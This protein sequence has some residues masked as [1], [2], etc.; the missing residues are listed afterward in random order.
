M[1]TLAVLLLG[2]VSLCIAAC[3]A[4]D[5]PVPPVNTPTDAH[6]A[7]SPTLAATDTPQPTATPAPTSK[8]IP[9]ATPSPTPTRRR[10]PHRR[11]F[12]PRR[13][14]TRPL[15]PL[16]PRQ[17]PLRR[18]PP[19]HPPRRYLRPLDRPPRL[20]RL[21]PRQLP[22]RC[23]S[24]R[25]RR[26]QHPRRP[27]PSA[28]TLETWRRTSACLPQLGRPTRCYHTGKTGRWW[29]CSTEG[30]GDRSAELSSAS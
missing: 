28:R 21:C 4:E 19:F 30:S 20:P 3:G 29:S 5:T 24:H 25:L 7:P 14:R 9:T 15:R 27:A 16:N 12:P 23:P 26:S 8:S 6:A 11:L 1:R 18:Q 17:R 10:L 22:H 13:R 2:I